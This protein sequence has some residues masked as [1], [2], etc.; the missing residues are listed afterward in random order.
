MN[1]VGA[2]NGDGIF[3]LFG[4]FLQ[5]RENPVHAN[6]QE[7]GRARHLNRQCRVENIGGGKAL[8]DEAGILADK[9]GEMG[10]KGDDVMFDFAL[11]LIDAGDVKFGRS[12]LVPDILGRGFRY[13]TKL[14][15][16]VTAMGL[17]LKPDAVFRGRRP[18]RGHL[19]AGI[20]FNHRDSP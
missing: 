4:A 8:M 6:Q 19:F 14:G 7:I 16:R 9:F 10:Q 13:N 17:N 5:R 15:Q 12:A 1:A 20:A 11:D 3:M 18:D 2:A